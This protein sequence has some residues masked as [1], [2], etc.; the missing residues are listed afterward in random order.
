M[1][2]HKLLYF[3]VENSNILKCNTYKQKKFKFFKNL[4]NRKAKR[5]EEIQFEF[6]A[7]QF[8]KYSAYEAFEVNT[9]FRISI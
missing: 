8:E 5:E 7:R 9:I 3:Q 4:F 2:E 6:I 1:V